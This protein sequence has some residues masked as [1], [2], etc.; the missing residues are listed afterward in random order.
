M[1][2]QNCP[3]QSTTF[4]LTLLSACAL[5]TFIAMNSAHAETSFSN[6]QAEEQSNTP[7]AVKRGDAL[8]RNPK[9]GGNGLTCDNCHPNS[10]ATHPQSWPRYQTNLSKVGTLREMMNWCINVSMLG[11]TLLINSDEMDDL[12]AYANYMHRYDA[13]GLAKSEPH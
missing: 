10:S 4:K 3:H 5:A 2:R 12:E 8:W 7:T 1:T 11:K 9:L 13:I 6:A